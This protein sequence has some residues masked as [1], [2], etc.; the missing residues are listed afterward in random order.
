MV[1]YFR[2][3]KNLHILYSTW[4]EFDLIPYVLLF[5]LTAFI[6][7]ESTQRPIKAMAS[8]ERRVASLVDEVPGL[9]PSLHVATSQL[10]LVLPNLAYY[11]SVRLLKTSFKSWLNE[12]HSEPSRQNSMTLVRTTKV[13]V[14]KLRT[15]KERRSWSARN[16]DML[17]RVTHKQL[18]IHIPLYLS[19]EIEI[20]SARFKQYI[21]QHYIY[22][23]S[24]MRQDVQD[25][26]WLRT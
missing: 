19:P 4:T 20:P 2:Q 8:G 5:R 6:L 18:R 1:S 23:K 10:L 26:H 7:T 17:T 9:L 11:D 12:L 24:G 14:V 3:W 21:E 15:S 16:E 13:M 25:S 22:T